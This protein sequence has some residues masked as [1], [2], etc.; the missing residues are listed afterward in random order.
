MAPQANQA[1]INTC[2]VFADWGR[3]ADSWLQELGQLNVSDVVLGINQDAA[4]FHLLMPEAEVAALVSAALG[5]GLRVHLM[6]WLL[7]DSAFIGTSAQTMKRLIQ[8]N[9]G[10]ASLL[11]DV[12]KSWIHASPAPNED[13]VGL[14]MNAYAELGV[15]LGVTSYALLPENVRPLVA[16]VKYGIP[17][18][19]SL[20]TPDGEPRNIPV[21]KLQN[22][23]YASWSK[24]NQS[25]SMGLAAYEQTGPGGTLETMRTAVAASE[26]CNVDSVFYWSLRAS[27][28]QSRQFIA[29][30]LAD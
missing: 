27:D 17:Q 19:Y 26:N 10:V 14:V 21:P 6:I 28:A 24:V 22:D 4:P 7:P 11:F 15:P 30:L 29:S 18:A 3:P 23:A 9:P 20:Y 8:A 25:I 12:E 13:T 2:G 1:P 5:A 16:R